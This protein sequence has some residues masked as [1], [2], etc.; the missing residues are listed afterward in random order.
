M[1]FLVREKKSKYIYAL[2]MMFK[3]QLQKSCVEHQVRREIE[4]QTHLDHPNCLK[5]HGFFYDSDRIY[6]ILEYVA[7]GE[8]YDLLTKAKRF[9]ESVAAN[10]TYQM[11]DVL[12]YLH[13]RKVIHR[14]IK[15]ENLLVDLMGN[16]KI[17]DFGWAVHAPSSRRDTLCGTLDYLPP[18]MVEGTSHSTYA[19]NWC[20]GVLLYEF[21]VGSPPFEAATTKDTYKRIVKCD[22][23]YPPYVKEGARDLISKLLRHDP[24]SRFSVTDVKTHPWVLQHMTMTPRSTS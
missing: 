11:A 22:V 1:V 19:D 3:D 4:I 18:E 12:E 6:L 21:L 10:Y 7:K 9:S 23:L 24:R 17:S 2:K 13:K 8:L 14:D 20:L 15:P 5:M 16:L